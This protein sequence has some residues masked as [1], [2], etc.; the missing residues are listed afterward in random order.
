MNL[1]ES[2]KAKR[3]TQTEL[4]SL[5]GVTETTIGFVE[6]GKCRPQRRTREQIENV[7]GNIDWDN[8]HHIG[9]A[10]RVVKDVIDHFLSRDDKPLDQKIEFLRYLLAKYEPVTTN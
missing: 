1:T 4:A 2:R 7:L 10:E 8:Q 9:H 3:L 5:C 6:Q